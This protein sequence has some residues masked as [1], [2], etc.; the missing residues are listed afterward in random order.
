MNLLK[1]AKRKDIF[2][3]F[4]YSDSLKFSDIEKCT[5]IRSNELAYFLQKLINEKILTKENGEYQLTKDAEK[6][7]PFFVED[8][9]LSPLPVVLVAIKKDDKYLLIHRVK[10]PYND[11]WSLVGGRINLDES[12]EHAAIRNVKEKTFLDV[13]FVSTN[14]IVHERHAENDESKSAFML[15][16]VLTEPISE[17]KEQD[18]LKWFTKEEIDQLKMIP[19]DKWL[20]LNKIN[21]TIDVIEET[22]NEESD[23]LSMEMN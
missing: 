18:N 21:S 3:Q 4:L 14:S 23:K 17:I 22:I 11:H 12:I 19:S 7:I 8:N 15:F 2:K 16:F 9:K 20:M 13:R 10:R 5:K 1:D 6:Y